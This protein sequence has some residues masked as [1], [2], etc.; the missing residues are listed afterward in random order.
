MMPMI[1]PVVTYL[2]SARA[3]LQLDKQEI[4]DM[5]LLRSGQG[6]LAWEYFSHHFFHSSYVSSIGACYKKRGTC[7]SKQ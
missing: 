2:W 7:K 3:P 4:G 1:P 6:I 5:G